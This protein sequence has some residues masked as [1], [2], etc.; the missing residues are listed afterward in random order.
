MN[1]LSIYCLLS[2]IS[3]LFLSGCQYPYYTSQARKA[4]KA[5][6]E[7]RKKIRKQLASL[8]KQKIANSDSMDTPSTNDS[9]RLTERRDTLPPSAAELRPDT[10]GLP[11]LP[12]DAEDSIF[13]AKTDSHW[14]EANELKTDSTYHRD[15][16]LYSPDSLDAPVQ[17]EATDSMWYDISA[18]KIHL[19]GEAQVRYAN[20]SLK[21]GYIVFDFNTNIAEARAVRDSAAKLSQY[22]YFEDGL[23]NFE[24]HR[25]RYNFKTK[26]GKVYDASTKQGTGFFLAKATKFISKDSEDSQKND[27]IYSSNAIYTTCNHKH[28]HFGIRISKAKVI[29]RKLI[30]AGPSFFEIMG[31]PVP[32]GLPFGF[33]PI[34]LPEAR[35][36]GLIQPKID[37]SPTLGPGLRGIGYYLPMGKHLDFQVTGDFYARGAFNLYAKLRYV[38]KYR[39]TGSFN[40]GY[41]FLKTGDKGT[42]EYD[43]RQTFNISWDHK[44]DNKA[45]PSQTF[46]A[47]L[48]FGSSNFYRN[49]SNTADEVLQGTFRSNISYTK[50]FVGTPFSTSI[51]FTHSQNTQN[52]TMSITLPRWDFRMNRIVPFQTKQSSGSSGERWYERIGFS[53]SLSAQNTLNTVDTIFFQAFQYGNL[54]EAVLDK[55]EYHVRHQPSLDFSF[56]LFKYLNVTPR[57]NYSE[58]WYFYQ[59]LQQFDPTLRIKFDTIYDADGN[60]TAVTQDT[61]FGTRSDVPRSTTYG[62]YPVRDMSA[63]VGLSTQFFAFGIFKLHKD[64]QPHKLR[65]TFTP[66]LGFQWRP[67]YSTDFWG[68]YDSVRTD[69]RYSD[70]YLRYQKFAAVP[71]SGKSALLN[72]SMGM[73]LE[74]KFLRA[75]PDS[76]QKG[77]AVN[78]K[79]VILVNQLGIS[80]NYNMAVDTLKWSV[81]AMSGNMTFFKQIRAN[82]NFNFDPYAANPETNA[83]INTFQWALNKRVLRMT[84]AGLRLSTALDAPKLREWFKGK[85]QAQANKATPPTGNTTNQ[86]PLLRNLSLNYTL[87]TRRQYIEG[88][89]S[90]YFTANNLG[91]NGTIDLSKGWRIVIGRV[92]YDFTLKR[93]TYPDFRFMRDLHCWEMEVGWQPERRTWNFTIRVKAAPLNVISI[94]VRKTI[95]DP[96]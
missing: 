92:G 62:L 60:I 8:G 7:W 55:M 2:F 87:T 80:G 15:S 22:P 44:Q 23:Q 3:C 38:K 40:L 66:N 50:R 81:I 53:Y 42:P 27:I 5:D 94:P 72:Y 36:T 93:F 37:Y 14:V 9:T 29:P 16:I 45:H 33:F 4:R 67:D 82:F 49:T 70:A 69:T 30:V 76:T 74:G 88:R 41:S 86:Y 21:A 31:T 56:K 47:S 32:L 57:V 96:F 77:D 48:N 68:Y 25:I 59:N 63:G 17:Y 75:Q 1:S 11:P 89:D 18:K 6:R 91:L 90:L 95:A 83:R 34:A 65:A 26:K 64:K 46:N 13:V 19:Y 39:Q 35:R 43:L 73:Q 85:K 12:I 28:P 58:T 61:T 54:Q 52:N 10:S 24:S 84:S 79:R 20:Y 78:Y 71:G 51:S